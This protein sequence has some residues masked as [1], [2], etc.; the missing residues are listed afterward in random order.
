MTAVVTVVAAGVTVIG[1]P[2]VVGWAHLASTLTLM[3]PCRRE[4]CKGL[5]KLQSK[6]RPRE[7]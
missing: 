4:D 5:T 6:K 7:T 1:V 2:P 3:S